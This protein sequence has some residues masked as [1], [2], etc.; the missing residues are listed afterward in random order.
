MIHDVR[1]KSGECTVPSKTPPSKE[2]GADT[3]TGLEVPPTAANVAT[4]ARTSTPCIPRASHTSAV[5]SPDSPQPCKGWAARLTMFGHGCTHNANSACRYSAYLDPSCLTTKE[6][7][8]LFCLI[9][10]LVI[11]STLAGDMGKSGEMSEGQVG[12]W[13]WHA[14]WQGRRDGWVVI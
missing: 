1:R 12:A 11:H 3:D 6:S 4:R 5:Q 7:T 2:S 13:D 9:A 14:V 8:D 10:T